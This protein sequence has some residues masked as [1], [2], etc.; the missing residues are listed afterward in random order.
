M[1]TKKKIEALSKI[2]SGDYSAAS[3]DIPD[4]TDIVVVSA[5]GAKS[6]VTDYIQKTD[7]ESILGT[8]GII[9]DSLK[10]HI[11]E[12]VKPEVYNYNNIPAV[13][14][15]NKDNYN[16][17]SNISKI[18]SSTIKQELSSFNVTPKQDSYQ[19]NTYEAELGINVL[20][21]KFNYSDAYTF[22]QMIV[23]V[24]SDDSFSLTIDQPVEFS[25]SYEGIDIPSIICI[26]KPLVLSNHNISLLIFVRK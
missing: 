9:R 19:H 6:T 17:L 2:N 14:S 8:E 5:S 21:Y 10:E 7:T 26:G 3:K 22:E 12:R 13:P 1:S 20:K 18:V 4:D 16:L 25:L 24:L 11:E 15:Q 23:F